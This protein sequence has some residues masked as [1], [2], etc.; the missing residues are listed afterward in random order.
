MYPFYSINENGTIQSCILYLVFLI[1]CIK[2][3][4]ATPHHLPKKRGAL[5]STQKI[6]LF[7]FR[8]TFG[9]LS[10]SPVIRQ[11]LK[12]KLEIKNDDVTA[13]VAQCEHSNIKCYTSAFSN[14]YQTSCQDQ[15]FCVEGLLG[16]AAY[17]A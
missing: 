9:G 11:C 6:S 4:V 3:N 15:N 14:I 16:W 17:E 1:F 2:K 13:D 10:Q 5:K 12:K 8:G 7:F